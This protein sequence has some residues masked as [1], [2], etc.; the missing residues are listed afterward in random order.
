MTTKCRASCAS[1]AQSS[2]HHVASWESGVRRWAGC[3]Q[4]A[5]PTPDS[6]KGCMERQHRTSR[7]ARG[8]RR[9]P[10]NVPMPRLYQAAARH[11]RKPPVRP[12]RRRSP[13]ADA[14]QLSARPRKTCTLWRKRRTRSMSSL[15]PRPAVRTQNPETRPP[16]APV[17]AFARRPGLPAL[18]CVRGRGLNGAGPAQSPCTM[19]RHG[20]PGERR[21]RA[22]RRAR[23]FERA[24]GLPAARWACA[25]QRAWAGASMW[26]LRPMFRAAP[27][28][29]PPFAGHPRASERR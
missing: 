5:L 25:L 7:H 28:M 4:S 27:W 15:R 18:C 9:T 23:A 10:G 22:L 16:A 26:C 19:G 21:Q 24:A 3:R 14:T 20:A 2:P 29:R 11:P 6:D 8:R 1:C 12:L 13:A 17:P